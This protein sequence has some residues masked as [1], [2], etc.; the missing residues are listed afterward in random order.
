M[1]GVLPTWLFGIVNGDG[2]PIAD[3]EDGRAH[4]Y[5]DEEQANAA[6]LAMPDNGDFHVAA[7]ACV[8]HN[9]PDIMDEEGELP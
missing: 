9:L 5:G 6:L 3:P 4:F 8:P 7:V 2:F 1:T